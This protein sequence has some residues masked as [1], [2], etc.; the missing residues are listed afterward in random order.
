ML[1]KGNVHILHTLNI[2][3]G[4][5]PGYFQTTFHIAVMFSD[6]LETQKKLEFISI[7]YDSKLF[8]RAGY[9]FKYLLYLQKMISLLT[10]P[11]T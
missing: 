1:S 7:L 11:V 3:L 8:S 10:L 6:K 5:L 2:H 4:L 9:Y